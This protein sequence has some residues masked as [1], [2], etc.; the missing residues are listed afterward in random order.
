[1]VE[2]SNKEGVGGEGTGLVFGVELGADEEG[3]EMFIQFDGFD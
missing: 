1:M 3:V 2:K